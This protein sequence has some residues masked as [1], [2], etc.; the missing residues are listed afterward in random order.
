MIRRRPAIPIL[1]V[2]GLALLWLVLAVPKLM[3]HASGNTADLDTGNYHHLAWAIG[4]LGPI[5]GFGSS[6]LGRHHLG[7][8]FSP[9]M[10]LMALPYLV[11]PSAYLLMLLQATAVWAAMALALWQAS[12]EL[13]EAGVKPAAARAA[14]V[15]VLLVMLLVYPPLT[16]TW[17]TQFQPVELAAPLVV[18]AIL[19]VHHGRTGWLWL[20]VPLLLSTRESAVLAVA[21]IGIYA[22]VAH[23]RWWL[24]GGLGLAAAA[25]GDLAMGVVMPHFRAGTDWGHTTY[26]GPLAA[27]D[28]KGPYLA[29]M[30]LGLGLFPLLGRKALAATLGAVP[31]LL[32][33]VSVDRWTQYG[34]AGHYDAHTAPFLMLAAAHGIGSVARRAE[35]MGPAAGP[36]LSVPIF[37]V[38]VALA[39]TGW[40]VTGI[41]TAFQR[42]DDWWPETSRLATL[43]EAR[44]MADRY[45]DAPGLTAHH[46]IGPH[47][48]ARPGYVA[49]RAG[50]TGKKW[51]WFVGTRIGPGH[52]FL[53]PRED[54]PFVKS[55][56]PG[57]VRRSG[58][59]TLLE[60]GEYVEVWQWPTDAPPPGTQKARAYAA[61]RY[62]D[63]DRQA[64]DDV[65]EQD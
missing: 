25:W 4:H 45:R 46:R 9:V 28:E 13:R 61:W 43:A 17:A 2:A 7:E 48:A 50:R 53:I 59:A 3:Q 33:N 12:R 30:L 40:G 10:V 51:A 15:A 57:Q 54:N 5:E 26:Y 8:H 1:V 11:W 20:V 14:G 42:Y 34:F 32:L 63:S 21:G 39:M 64:G 36:R 47:V 24:A 23:G 16:A 35:A 19:L 37:A 22:A 38:S 49:E 62:D 60:R 65:D 52:V 58:S 31:G 44:M 41:K 55:G 6:V 27:W 56:L 29:V 18:L